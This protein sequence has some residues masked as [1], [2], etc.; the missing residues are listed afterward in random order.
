M[1]TNTH[2]ADVIA[3]IRKAGSSMSELARAYRL[4]PSSFTHCLR[5]PIPEANRAIAR[6]LGVTPSELWP[7]WFDE[8]G[9]RRDLRR[10]RNRP[11]PA[12]GKSQNAGSTADLRRVA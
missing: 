1:E 4:S 12:Q 6:F 3:S 2:P 5:R 10:S 7:D 11:K 9:N 8:Q